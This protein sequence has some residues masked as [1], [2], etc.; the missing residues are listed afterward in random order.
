M[1]SLGTSPAGASAME[2]ADALLR[3]AMVVEE[4][5]RSSRKVFALY[6]K[7]ARLFQCGCTARSDTHS[8]KAY[9]SFGRKSQGG[10][11]PN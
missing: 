2:F 9:M 6:F 11:T 7:A 1:P 10:A 4:S 3:S 5:R 8:R